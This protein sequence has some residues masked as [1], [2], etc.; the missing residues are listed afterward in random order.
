MGCWDI[1]CF[2]CGNTCHGAFSDLNTNLIETMNYYESIKDSK[3]KKKKWFIDYYSEVYKNYKKDPKNFLDKI[4]NINKNTKWL[5]KCTFLSADG[6]INHNCT[7]IACN[8]SFQDN[9][10]K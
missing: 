8:V 6:S 4:K 7:E 2:L 9:K 3:N 10:A 1:F 5:N